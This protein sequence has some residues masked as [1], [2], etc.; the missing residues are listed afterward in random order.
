MQELSHI[1]DSLSEK[2]AIIKEIESCIPEERD[3]I[4]AS[5]L[6]LEEEASDRKQERTEKTQSLQQQ[7]QQLKVSLKIGKEGLGLLTA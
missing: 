7:Q 1:E 4:A 3:G 2:T 5:Q 6:R